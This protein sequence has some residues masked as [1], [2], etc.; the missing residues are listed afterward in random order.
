MPKIVDG[1]RDKAKRMV[2]IAMKAMSFMKEGE[3]A[4]GRI[5][6][7]LNATHGVQCLATRGVSTSNSPNAAQGT[8]RHTN[9]ANPCTS[10]LLATG[11]VSG[12]KSASDSSAS[13]LQ[14]PSD[15]IASCVATLLMIQTCTER[16]YPPAEVAQILDNAV[17]SLHP[18]CSQNLA[19]YRE[20]QMCMG[21][22]KTQILA[23]V[24]T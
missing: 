2:D 13:D 14:V 24:P 19:I 21:R 6:E 16:Q 3:D 10:E 18:H 7:A 17:T 8:L 15:L 4:Y 11:D 12:I 23:L 5:G 1:S 22:I 20:I 9:S